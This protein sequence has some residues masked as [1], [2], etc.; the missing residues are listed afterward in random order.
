M[1]KKPPLILDTEQKA[2]KF[3]GFFFFLNCDVAEVV[4]IHK[5]I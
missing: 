4:I 1:T 5:M 2:P 3:E